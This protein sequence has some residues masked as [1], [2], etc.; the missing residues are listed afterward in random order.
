M[1]LSDILRAMQE[2]HR[3]GMRAISLDGGE[4][5][6]SEH[7]ESVVD[8]LHDHGVVLRINTNGVLVGQHREAIRRMQKVK[9]SLDGPP[10]VHDAAR[11][12]KAFDR[13]VRGAM[14]ARELGVGVELTCVLGPHNARDI[15][16]LLDI[17]A[18]MGFGVVFQPMRKSLLAAVAQALGPDARAVLEAFRRIEQRKAQGAPVLN[19]WSSLRHFRSWPA[20]RSLPCAAGWINATL[21]PEGNLYACGQFD[22]SASRHNVVKLGTDDAFRHLV[23]SGCS[24][25]WCARVVEENYAWGMRFDMNLPIRQ[26]G[27]NVAA[28]ARCSVENPASDTARAE[29]DSAPTFAA[30]AQSERRGPLSSAFPPLNP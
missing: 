19:R 2:L 7:F 4:P 28:I 8:W 14:I 16:P 1:S 21:D 3:I 24:Q 27:Q 15:D 26:H 18:S 11:G 22:R 10:Q 5:L 23:R 25:C 29:S 20:N 6:V 9:I 13:A 17:A 12:H 30:M